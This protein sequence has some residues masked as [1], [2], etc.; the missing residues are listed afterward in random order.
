MWSQVVA[1][2]L[3][4]VCLGAVTD[5]LYA[6]AAGTLGRFLRRRH[7]VLR[8]GSGAAYIGLGAATAVAKRT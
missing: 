4:F 3:L 8:W 1:L 6:V 2:G 7:N 5:S